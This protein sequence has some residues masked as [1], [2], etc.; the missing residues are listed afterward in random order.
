MNS[1][2]E[3]RLDVEPDVTR[4]LLLVS[5]V[6]WSPAEAA[7][8]RSCPFSNVS[9]ITYITKEELIGTGQSNRLGID[10]A[11]ATKFTITRT[12]KM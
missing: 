7:I 5:F 2:G 6:A 11:N 8:S 10:N 12:E 3:G 4:P 9:I 1:L